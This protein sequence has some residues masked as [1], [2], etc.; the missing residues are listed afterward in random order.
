[1]QI[2]RIGKVNPHFP[3]LLHL[4]IQ[5]S[6]DTSIYIAPTISFTEM[7]FMIEQFLSLI[8]YPELWSKFL[9]TY[10]NLNQHHCNSKKILISWRSLRMNTR[11][12]YQ[13]AC[14]TYPFTTFVGNY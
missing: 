8:S 4:E 9:E 12:S 13:T 6:G 2:F 14:L 11:L 3:Y 10:Q 1:M 7:L 5:V